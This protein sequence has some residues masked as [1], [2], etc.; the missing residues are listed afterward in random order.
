VGITSTSHQMSLG[1]TG[2][3]RVE[4]SS[5]RDGQDSWQTY[6]HVIAFT[7]LVLPWTPANLAGVDAWFDA[8]DFSTFTLS[9]TSVQQWN[10][11]SANAIHADAPTSTDPARVAAVINGRAVV[12]FGG[13]SL[14]RLGYSTSG[15]NPTV[16]RALFKNKTAA[17]AIVV[18]RASPA[19]TTSTNNRFAFIWTN[20]ANQTTRF[21]LD[22]NRTTRL[23][24][25]H[26][27]TRRAD[28]DAAAILVPP[29][30][31][32][33]GWIIAVVAIDW[34]NNDAWLYENGDLTASSTTHGTAG[35]TANT[36]SVSASIG[37]IMNTA[38]AGVSG[39]FFRGDIAE[40]VIADEVWAT[41]DRQRLE[42]YMAWKWGLVANLPVL[43]PWKS[44]P[45]TP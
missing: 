9:G 24:A 39:Q 16:A 35:A 26:L 3:V 40:I 6:Q 19:D 45:P 17:S 28:A 25:P 44:T 14:L 5:A 12:R 37:G 32:A 41:A 30:D 42:G 29:T 7:A 1:F 31:R 21:A 20:N 33:D 43:H 34:Q 36:D 27:I 4:L 15:V 2:N 8:D 13:A 22:C 38:T 18:L 11:K 10:D 23:N